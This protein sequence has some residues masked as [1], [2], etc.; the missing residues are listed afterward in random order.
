MTTQTLRGLNGLDPLHWRG[1]RTN[2]NH[3]NGAFISLLGGNALS[4]PDMNAYRAF[5]NTVVFQPNPNQNLDR[6]YSTNVVGGDANAGR[7]AFF[8][9]NYTGSGV[10]GLKCTS[11]HTGPPGPGSDNLIIPAVALQE[12]QDFKVPHLRNAYQKMSFNNAPNAVSIGGFGIVHD[13]TDPSLQVFLSRQVFVNIL[14]NTAIKNNL[15][16][17]VQS[18]DTGTAPAVGYTR[19]ISAANVSSISVSND[20]ALLE[21]QAAAI[22]NID[23]VVKGTIDGKLRGLLY[24]PGSGYK[25]DS[26]NI[27]ALTHAQLVAKIVAGDRLTIMGVPPGSGA[28]MG[29]DRDEDGVLDGDLPAPA[30]QIARMGNNAVINWPYSAAGFNLET[31]ALLSPSGWT[32][33]NEPV[34]ILTGQNFV[35]NSLTSGGAFFR[36]RFQ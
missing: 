35:T 33:A 1:D 24:Q 6:T 31:T 18:F 4:V 26:T 15:A 5:I 29:I 11:C 17:F 27:A 25:T 30:L 22:T 16:A 19:T 9:T 3:F 2:F 36:L 13:G 10:T 32:N 23:L 20:W 12:S 14:N 28:R 34:E 7:N 21:N 8:F